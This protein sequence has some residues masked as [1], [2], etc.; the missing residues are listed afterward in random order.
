M[1][2]AVI[3]AT[4]RRPARL[5]IVRPIPDNRQP[6]SAHTLD[7]GLHLLGIN[8][9]TAPLELREEVAFEQQKMPQL[10]DELCR[11][12]Y[13]DEGLIL[14]TCNRTEI[15]YVSESAQTDAVHGWL[16]QHAQRA[17]DVIK[18]LYQKSD[19]QTVEHACRVAAGLDSLVLGE[20]QIFGQLKTAHRLAQSQGTLGASLH[21]L[22]KHAFKAAKKVRTETAIGQ[23]SVSAASVSIGL[24][25][26]VFTGFSDK[27]AL[28]VGAGEM[29]EIAGEHLRAKDIGSLII[30]NR[31]LDRGKALA[32]KLNCRAI[33]LAQLESVLPQCDLIFSS[34]ASTDT[35]IKAQAVEAALK[36]RKRRPLFIVDLAV[37]RDV[38]AEI[39]NF[40]DVFLYTIDDLHQA[41]GDNLQARTVAAGKA[42]IIINRL[43]D[44][45]ERS[46]DGLNAVPVIRE[47]RSHGDQ[48]KND[49]LDQAK[50]QLAA[51]R[52]VEEV[53]QGLA[54]SL[55][56]KLLHAPSTK[57]R[58][59]AEQS[60]R[61]FLDEVRRLFNLTK[62]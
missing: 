34:T 20:P 35:V 52:N 56:A 46:Q 8:H 6:N 28:M 4:T 60:D 43:N 29:I 38:D 17:D 59:A 41:I 55:V 47:L 23:S 27:T 61:D 37:P 14:S 5:V 22:F 11:V 15:Y 58:E 42:H 30:A 12:P 49:M 31:S 18:C 39:A 40:S 54:D 62:R 51:G 33:P 44:E 53:M 16:R 25:Q 9:R 24:A 36:K 21:R 7:M 19:R 26:Q 10:L 1:R 45:F 13:I 57:L 50:R 3:K 32:K 2:R 48:I